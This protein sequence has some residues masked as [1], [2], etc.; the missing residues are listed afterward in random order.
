MPYH[1]YSANLV[2]FLMMILLWHFY[3]LST[4][5]STE[6]VAF[7]PVHVQQEFNVT[8]LN[9]QQWSN[10]DTKGHDASLATVTG[11]VPKLCWCIFMAIL[12]VLFSAI[13]DDPFGNELQD[14]LKDMVVLMGNIFVALSDYQN[15]VQNR[16]YYRVAGANVKF[17]VD[18][19]VITPQWVDQVYTCC[20]GYPMKVVNA[21]FLQEVVSN[22]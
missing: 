10:P 16:K 7:L 1:V 14:W 21:E 3:E 19:S 5:M 20:C 8:T 22:M 9:V 4:S 6:A 13:P 17:S 15:N 12:I 11:T 18:R 2:K